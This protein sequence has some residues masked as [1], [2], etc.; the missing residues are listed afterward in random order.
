MDSGTTE[1]T[2][3]RKKL[4]PDSGIEEWHPRMKVEIASGMCLPVEFRG[5]MLMKVREPGRTSSKK[6]TNISV[7]HSL[8][9]KQMPVTLI[10]TK[11]LLRYCGIR[12]YFNDELCMVLPCPAES[13]RRGCRWPAPHTAPREGRRRPLRRCGGRCVVRGCAVVRPGRV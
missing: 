10:S 6:V 9:V 13:R 11:A 2:S 3:G 1:C 5:T 4:F 8:Y 7:P 12:T